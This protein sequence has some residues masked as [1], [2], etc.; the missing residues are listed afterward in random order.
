[1][2]TAI[3]GLVVVYISSGLHNGTAI[4]LR[5][6]TIAGLR[7][8]TAVTGLRLVSGSIVLVVMVVVYYYSGAIR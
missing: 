3:V 6:V 5:L 8:I 7:L 4:R 1:M 2:V